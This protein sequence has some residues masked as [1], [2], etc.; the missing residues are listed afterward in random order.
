MDAAMEKSTLSLLFLSTTSALVKVG[1]KL[2]RRCGKDSG[3]GLPFKDRG[4]G[5]DDSEKALIV[6]LLGMS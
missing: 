6:G 2:G 3:F 5:A 1:K 4:L